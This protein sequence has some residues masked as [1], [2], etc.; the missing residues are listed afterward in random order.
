MSAACTPCCGSD[1]AP[2]A[3]L[4]LLGEC[5]VALPRFYGFP[6][7]SVVVADLTYVATS[8]G[9][10]YL[11]T[12]LDAWSRRIVGWAMGDTLRTDLVVDALNIAVW[13]WISRLESQFRKRQIAMMLRANAAQPTQARVAPAM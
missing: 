4:G 2:G 3:R 11:A 1:P 13:T 9:W 12:V 5:A 8:E 10:L 6:A 7:R